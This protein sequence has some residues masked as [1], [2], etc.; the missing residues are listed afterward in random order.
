MGFSSFI[1][2]IIMKDTRA[3][4]QTDFGSS[5]CEGELPHST[6]ESQAN[7]TDL[8]ASVSSCIQQG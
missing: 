2:I 4:A 6:G 1:L 3:R 7:L 5:D 8:S